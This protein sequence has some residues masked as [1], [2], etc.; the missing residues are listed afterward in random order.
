MNVGVPRERKAG[1]ARV[2]LSPAGA[3][4]LVGRG[5]SVFVETDAGAGS[6]IADE[7]FARAGATIVPSADALFAEARMV[8]KVKEPS[9]EEIGRLGADHLLFTYLHLAA[10]PAVATGLRDCGAIAV[11]YETVELANGMLPLLAPM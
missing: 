3:R 5:H 10:Y 8:V 11:A 4:E 7:E 2:A 6:R 1:E 9:Q